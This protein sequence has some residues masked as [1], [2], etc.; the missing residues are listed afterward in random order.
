M[1][2]NKYKPEFTKEEFRCKCGCNQAEMKEDFMD[3]LHSA[4]KL[5]NRP[6]IITSGYRCEKHN[7][8][9]GGTDRSD[10]LTGNGAD[11][12]VRSGRERW[13]IEDALIKCGFI[14]IGHGRDFIHCGNRFGNPVWVKWIY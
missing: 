5:A 4:R 9:V 10:H 6:F 11:I 3:M 14:R 7:K 13:V 2:W 8:N 12:S 1:D